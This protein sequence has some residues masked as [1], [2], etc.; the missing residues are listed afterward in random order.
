[1]TRPAPNPTTVTEQLATLAAV[2]GSS[3]VRDRHS[4]SSGE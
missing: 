3:G 1:M 4:D 2:I